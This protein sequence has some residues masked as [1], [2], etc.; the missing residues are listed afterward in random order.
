VL[1]TTDGNEALEIVRSRRVHVVVSDQRMPIMLGVE[2][3]RQVRE[4]SPYTMR[5][6]LTGYSDLGAVIDSI[7]EGEIFRY[8]SKPWN[9]DEIRTTLAKAVEIALSLEHEQ[10]I[11]TE[12]QIHVA[13]PSEGVLVIDDDP[14]TAGLVGE[15][16]EQELGGGH[17]VYWGPDLKTAFELLTEK[18]IAVVVTETHLGREEIAGAIKTLKRYH[19]H[20]MA[21]VLTSFKD[22][23]SLVQLI[24]QGQVHRF[25]PKPASHNLLARALRSAMGRYRLMRSRPQLVRTQQVEESQ[26]SEDVTI[27]GRIPGFVKR[28]RGGTGAVALSAEG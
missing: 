9:P 24:N 16:V 10:E 27:T 7:N 17:E 19:P 26:R 13:R 6:L 23:G 28:M 3:L 11:H 2:L 22:T 5:L 15:V 4:I 1:I 25:L 8:I 14:A 18:D 20:L 21:V 12:T